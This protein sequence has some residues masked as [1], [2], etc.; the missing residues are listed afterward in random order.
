MWRLD[1]AWQVSYQRICSGSWHCKAQIW[2]RRFGSTCVRC[3]VCKFRLFWIQRL[4]VRSRSWAWSFLARLGWSFFQDWSLFAIPWVGWWQ[5][6]DFFH[7]NTSPTCRCWQRSLYIFAT[8]TFLFFCLISWPLI[9]GS[10]VI[11]G[12]RGYSVSGISTSPGFRSPQCI[13]RW[14]RFIHQMI[15][16][17]NHSFS[18]V[19]GT[20]PLNNQEFTFL[21]TIGCKTSSW[22]HHGN[23]KRKGSSL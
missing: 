15:H 10:H 1:H 12:H 17:T 11:R 9:L 6:D 22:E 14:R 4:P 21:Q 3:L 5:I 19:R 7:S 23:T 20:L 2:P 16:A 18:R 13:F 8:R